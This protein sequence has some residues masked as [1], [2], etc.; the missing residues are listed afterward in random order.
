MSTSPLDIL[1]EI[2]PGLSFD[3]VLGETVTYDVTGLRCG[4]SPWKPSSDRRNTPVATRTVPPFRCF[5]GRWSS[6]PK[7]GTGSS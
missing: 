5:V 1:T 6:G 7:E 3:D 2:A 4:C